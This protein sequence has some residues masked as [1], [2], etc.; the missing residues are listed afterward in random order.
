[1]A[2]GKLLHL[3]APTNTSSSNRCLSCQTYNIS[4][5]IG[6]GPSNHQSQMMINAM[7]NLI[8]GLG[9][10]HGYHSK[11]K[12]I[13]SSNLVTITYKTSSWAWARFH[14]CGM[15][16][17]SNW[18]CWMLTSWKGHTYKCVTQLDTTLYCICSLFNFHWIL[19]A[20]KHHKSIL[21]RCTAQFNIWWVACFSS[22]SHNNHYYKLPVLMPVTYKNLKWFLICG[23]KIHVQLL[24]LDHQNMKELHLYVSH[25]FIFGGWPVSHPKS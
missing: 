24:L 18:C 1:M 17:M 9:V 6:L 25:N 22:N 7:H 10:L 5:L 12:N 2:N 19:K 3:H 11:S 20:S 23:A 21:K 14:S 16:N 4:C 15:Y 8:L 13:H